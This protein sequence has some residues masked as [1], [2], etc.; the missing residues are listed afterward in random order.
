MSE[1]NAV[2][3]ANHHV[4]A[5]QEAQQSILAAEQ[6]V[7]SVMKE[8]R[9]YG[10]PYKGSDKKTLL[11]PGA[12]LLLQ[13]FQLLPDNLE[14]TVTD[15]GNGHREVTVK[16]YLHNR[17]TGK[18]MAVGVGSCSTMESKYRWRNED[19]FEVTDLPIPRDSKEK[20]AEYR[21]QGFIMKKVDNEWRWC[22]LLGDGRKVENPDIAD[23][24]NTVLKQAKKRAL[25]DATITATATSEMFTQD[26]E[27]F[28]DFNPGPVKTDF[29]DVTENVQPDT[30]ECTVI[31]IYENENPK[32]AQQGWRGIDLGEGRI[33]ETNDAAL[34]AKAK[35]F[36]ETGENVLVMVE[37]KP[38]A[39]FPQLK[40]ITET[41]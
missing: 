27:D 36:M 19:G 40:S 15:L 8:N 20:K 32:L 39:D 18:C 7:K 29:K 26:V 33:A 17:E 16:A 24:Y 9:H 22:K 38:G 6:L 1:K 3:L 28:P 34:V 11:K 4:A 14:T 23:T 12:E 10:P 41:T 37:R 2:Q 13:I 30:L 35:T 5:I 21:K 31:G 25:V